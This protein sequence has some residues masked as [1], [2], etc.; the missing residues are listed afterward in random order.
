MNHPQSLHPLAK[1]FLV[2][3]MTE[4]Q[5][6]SLLEV[7][8][9]YAQS[10]ITFAKAISE[11]KI[12]TLESAHLRWQIAQENIAKAQLQDRI[13][14]IHQDAQTYQPQ[15]S[16]DMIFLDGPK[17]QLLTHF[18]H[19]IPYLNATG[20]I[21]ID[22]IDFHGL[23]DQKLEGR[24]NLSAMMRKLVHFVE[25]IEAH[26]DYVTQV[27]DIGDGLMRVWRKYPHLKL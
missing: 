10:S 4:H 15:K 3:W 22:N 12:V 25:L 20:S 14:L 2:S 6:T 19:F 8:T 7:G 5:V 21:W 11:L 23:R 16:F 27:Y 13:E 1:S 26:P 9:G 24:R 18:Y 17:A